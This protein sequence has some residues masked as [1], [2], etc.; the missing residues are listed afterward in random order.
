V[1][2][3]N[4]AN[5][6]TSG[7]VVLSASNDFPSAWQAFL[8][9]PA[10]GADQVLTV[11]VSAS[12]F[13]NWTRG[14]TITITALTALATSQESGNF[15]LRPEAPLPTTDVTLTPVAGVSE[16]NV[17]SGPVAPP[18]GSLGTW[19]FK[20]RTAASGDFRS[21]TADDVGDVLLLVAFSAA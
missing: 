3:D 6:P 17:V 8:A 12:R 18:P 4:A 19:S 13:P 2:A 7:A 15:V 9:Q 16:P 1:Q 11:N 5:A 20:L 21:L 14:K 10:G